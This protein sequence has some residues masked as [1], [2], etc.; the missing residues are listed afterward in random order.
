MR[1]LLDT[2]V[3]L[4][5]AGNLVSLTD[6]IRD[7]IEDKTN[8]LHFSAG[9]IW[10]VAIKH[11]RGRTDFQADPTRLRHLLSENGYDELAVTSEHAIVAAKLPPLHKDPFDRLLVAQAIVE[12]MTLVTVDQTVMRYPGL[13]SR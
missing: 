5:S 3:L 8:D 7:L 2:H 9:S 6:D 13:R 11:A 12:D 1:L 4:W 10:E